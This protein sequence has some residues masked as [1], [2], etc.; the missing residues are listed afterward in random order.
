ME[1]AVTGV[2]YKSCIVATVPQDNNLLIYSDIN[3]RQQHAV[4]ITRFHH[5]NRALDSDLGVVFI[6]NEA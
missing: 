1:Y 4:Y 6:D 3:V 2:L 5:Y